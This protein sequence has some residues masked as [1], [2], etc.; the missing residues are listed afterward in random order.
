MRPSCQHQPW[1]RRSNNTASSPRTTR[2]TNCPSIA[3]SSPRTT[4]C[5]DYPSIATS[6]PRTTRC[7]GKQSHRPPWLIQR[8]VKTGASIY[9]PRPTSA[10]CIERPAVP[11]RLDQHQL[12]AT[13]VLLLLFDLDHTSYRHQPSVWRQLSRTLHSTCKYDNKLSSLLYLLPRLCFL[14][15]LW[16]SLLARLT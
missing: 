13:I 3:A 1:P 9:Q 4:R 14:P 2:S 7:T 15:C 12:P 5:T 6:S 10:T 8:T 16:L 11:L